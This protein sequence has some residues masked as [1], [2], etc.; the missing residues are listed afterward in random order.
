M[1]EKK[2]ICKVQS[3]WEKASNWNKHGTTNAS[4]HS[5]LLWLRWD[6]LKLSN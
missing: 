4:E 1:N 5:N 6:V 2:K 3:L